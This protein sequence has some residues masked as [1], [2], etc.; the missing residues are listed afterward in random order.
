MS[1]QISLGKGPW[2]IGFLENALSLAGGL[3]ALNY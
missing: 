1:F 2:S 3:L